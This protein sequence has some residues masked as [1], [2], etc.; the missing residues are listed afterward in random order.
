MFLK[1]VHGLVLCWLGGVAA[2]ILRQYNSSRVNKAIG[3]KTHNS[4]SL[5]FINIEWDILLPYLLSSLKIVEMV[6]GLDYRS[7]QERFPALS[8]L[9]WLLVF[10]VN[11][12]KVKRSCLKD[13]HATYTY[14]C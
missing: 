8:M 12:N 4:L 3:D 10:E 5:G 13:D 2:R 1:D 14:N 6:P 9:W 7:Y 11:E